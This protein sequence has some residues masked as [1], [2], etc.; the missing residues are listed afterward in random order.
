MSHAPII[1]VTG[2]DT[3][4]GKTLVT[5][6]LAHRFDRR[7]LDVR[8]VKPVE[9]GIDE[10]ADEERDGHRLA[11][12]ARQET[13]PRALVELTRP[14]APPEAADIDGVD[15]SMDEWCE[16]IEAIAEA[17]DLVFVEGAGGLL[18]PLTWQ[19]S[20]RELADALGA[21]AL[22]VAPDALGVLNHTLMTLE[23]LEAAGIPLAGVVFSR[24]R[25]ADDSTDKNPR[26]L[27]RVAEVDRVTSVPRVD[28]WASAAEHLD[29]AVDWIA[30]AVDVP[31]ADG[32]SR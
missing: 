19:T 6:A 23:V 25:E 11:R 27:R 22:V 21:P 29:A 20:A 26:T 9:S 13:P 1:V 7:G 15:L 2:T 24:S 30:D 4:I 18:S 31:E 28:G 5:C 16:E 14:L 32:G 17:A 8:A 10:L 3:E 12:A